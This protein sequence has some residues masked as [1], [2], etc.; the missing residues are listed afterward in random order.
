MK[1]EKRHHPNTALR[2]LQ[3]IQT[4]LDCFTYIGL[5]ETT[6]S[7]ISERSG[8]SIGSVYH[9]FK[10]KDQLAAAVYLEGIIEYQKGLVESLTAEQGPREGIRAVVEFHLR[11]VEQ[12][13]R[14]ALYL[15][16]KRNARFMEGTDSEFN[17]LNRSFAAEIGGWFGRH[18]KAGHIRDLPRDIIISIMLGPCQ[19]FSRLYLTGKNAT[20]VDRAVENISDAVW[21]ALRGGGNDAEGGYHG[22]EKN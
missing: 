2:R 7:V 19:E 6:M 3:I 15:F 5:N 22:S 9:H 13:P 17:E 16:R 1:R 11:W 12:N 8:A 18:I 14:W 21:V 10:S 20:P 4:A